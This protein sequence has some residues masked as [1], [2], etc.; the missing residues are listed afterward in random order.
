MSS[1]T[2]HS[3][4]KAIELITKMN[5]S[6]I[7]PPEEKEPERLLSAQNMVTSNG[8][9][10]PRRPPNAFFIFRQNVI[11]QARLV[12]RPNMQIISKASSILW[13]M[14]AEEDRKC[15]KN[16]ASQVSALHKQRFPGFRYTP[17]RSEI[18]FKWQVSS[19]TDF[20]VPVD[21]IRGF[22]Y[23]QESPMAPIGVNMLEEGKDK[24]ESS[25]SH[26]ENLSTISENVPFA[27]RMMNFETSMLFSDDSDMNMAYNLNHDF[28]NHPISQIIFPYDFTPTFL[29]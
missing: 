16:L 8:I 24:L 4:D 13:K 28:M 27:Q 25:Q 20:K 14:A 23:I 29:F 18:V 11:R 15:Y 19:P 1:A 9:T 2:V 10:R 26:H 17:A 21:D 5:L 12:G 22:P 7:F 3:L 6:K